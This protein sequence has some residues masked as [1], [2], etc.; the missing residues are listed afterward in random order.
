MNCRD[1]STETNQDYYEIPPDDGLIKPYFDWDKEL[2]HEPTHEEMIQEAK[3]VLKDFKKLGF[4]SRGTWAERHG[5]NAKGVHKISFRAWVPG[6]KTTKTEL[7]KRI[8]MF[9]RAWYEAQKWASW[10]TCRS[11]GAVRS[12]NHDPDFSKMPADG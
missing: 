12:E 9:K 6:Y 4:D 1:D 10:G 5:K 2:D 8:K 3:Q 7:D 11:F